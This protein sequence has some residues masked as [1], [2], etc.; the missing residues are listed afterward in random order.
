MHTVET[1]EGWRGVMVKIG[2]GSP[3]ARGIAAASVAALLSYG[4]KL[5]RAAFRRDGTLRPAKGSGHP[6]ATGTHFLL[7]PVTAGLV[8]FLFT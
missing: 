7:V 2:L 4:F 1:I 3:V 8:V 6:D 5:P